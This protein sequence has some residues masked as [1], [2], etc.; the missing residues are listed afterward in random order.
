MEKQNDA[1]SPTYEL[2]WGFV[3]FKMSEAKKKEER[4]MAQPGKGVAAQ[5]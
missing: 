3:W 4:G 1:W 2:P 5:T